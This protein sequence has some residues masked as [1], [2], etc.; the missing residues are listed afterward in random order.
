MDSENGAEPIHYYVK[1]A[2][3][4]KVDETRTL[5]VDFTHLSAFTWE[6]P[7][8]IDRLQSEYVR[9]EPYLSQALTQFLAEEGHVVSEQ[10]W[11]QV[12]VYNLP[13]VNKI[14]DLKT[15]NLGKVMSIQGT[16]TRTTEVKPELM[17]GAFRCN[18][19]G[20]LNQGVE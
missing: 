15:E 12:G 2:R 6:D 10:C 18:Q 17:I 3:E 16:V 5:Y 14:R 19:C 4:L 13:G 11:Y 7:H 9:F 1:V 20:F 8:F